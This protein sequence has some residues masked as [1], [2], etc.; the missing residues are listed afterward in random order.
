MVQPDTKED[1]DM[2]E[3]RLPIDV[4]PN[5]DPPIFKWRQLVDTPSGKQVVEHQQAIPATIEVAVSRMVA[6]V[7]QLLH[8]NAVLRGTVE[9]M[10]ERIAAQSEF[11]G[12]KAEAPVSVTQ[13]SL[14]KGRG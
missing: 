9:G 3:I 10:A 2:E 13:A 7:K 4:V 1:G 14:K 11:L 12:K 5:T 6:I 8:D